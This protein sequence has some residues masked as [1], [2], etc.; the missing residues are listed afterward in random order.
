[1]NSDYDLLLAKKI[2][3][4]TDRYHDQPLPNILKL[5]EELGIKSPIHNGQNNLIL[6][7]DNDPSAVLNLPLFSFRG[8][9]RVYYKGLNKKIPTCVPNIF[10]LGP[11]KRAL[12]I[13]RT[14]MFEQKASELDIVKRWLEQSYEY[15]DKFLERKVKLSTSLTA[16]AQHFGLA[17]NLLDLTYDFDVAAFFATT[18]Y[19]DNKHLPCKNGEGV[20]YIFNSFF[21]FANEGDIELDVMLLPRAKEQS[22][23]ALIM[24][25]DED[26]NNKSPLVMIRFYQDIDCSMEILEQYK[27][28]SILFPDNCENREI[29]NIKDEVMN[30]TKDKLLAEISDEVVKIRCSE[31]FV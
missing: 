24:R 12:E 1:M 20:I 4:V 23:V 6:Q 10:R 21:Y 18:E 5:K 17:T 7:N 16:I 28:G 25:S 15:Q 9:N 11:E 8:Q 14:I 31:Y 30:M 2:K 22:A 29:L 13:R 19:K 3:C 27:N 26:F